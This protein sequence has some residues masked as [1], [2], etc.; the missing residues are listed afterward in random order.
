MKIRAFLI[1]LAILATSLP[2]NAQTKLV[3]SF[4]DACDS[5]ST[6]V[7]ERTSVDAKLK[8]RTITQRGSSLDFY[9]TN[10][11]TD[12]PWTK[13]DVKWFREALLDLFPSDAPA[14]SVGS[15][16]G[17]NININELTTNA[18]HFDGTV[19][20][21]LHRTSDHRGRTMV[22]RI[23]GQEFEKGLSGRHLAVWQSHGRYYETKTSRWEWQR[24]QNFT[25]VEDMYTQ[26]YVIP[27]LIPMLENAGAYVLSPR[28]R[29]TQ[30][31]EAVV[32]N[33]P[34]FALPRPDK[35]RKSGSYRESGDWYNAGMGFADIKE[36]YT[37]DDNPF[38]M[39]TARAAKVHPGSSGETKVTWTPD[40]PE[41]GR[42]AV[43]VSY[44][45]LSNSS[46]HAH[47]TVRHKG[48]ETEFA[49]NQKMGGSTWI[50]L[51][52]FDFDKEGG[53]VILD[54]KA[55]EGMVNKDGSVITADAVRFGGGMG[56][57]ARGNDDVPQDEW[58]TSGMP[59]YMEG[60]LY[61]M[62]WAG[63]DTTIIRKHP[64]DYTNDFADRGPWAAMMSGGSRVNPKMEGKGIPFDLS[65]A[66]HSD[67]GTFPNDSIIGTLSIYTLKEDGSRKYPDGEDRMACRDLCNYVQSQVV[68]D[69]RERYEPEWARREIWDRSY[70]EARTS[71]VPGMILELLSHQNFADMKYGLD[72]AFRFDVS[73]AV[74]KGVLKFLSDRYGCPYEVQPL[75][76]H[77]FASVLT[78]NGVT[79]SWAPTNDPIEPTAV[80]RGFILYTRID[81]GAFDDGRIIDAREAGG[82]YKA[83]V[84]MDPGHIYSFRIA[85]FND[86]GVSFPSETL[87]AGIPESPVSGDKVM[88]VNNFSRVSAPAWFDTPDYAGFDYALDSGVPYMYDISYIGQQY[89]FRRE[90]EWIDDDNPGFGGSYTDEAGLQAAGNTFDY[91]YVHG[92][93]VL[94]RG[95]AFS[96]MG[97]DA[98]A[99]D[100][101]LASGY[102]SMDVICGKQVTTS[103]GRGAVEDRYQVFPAPLQKA[104]SDYTAKGGNILIS[105]S[106]IGTDVWDQIYPAVHKDASYVSRT[107]RF[108]E[109]VLGYRWLT[110]YASRSGML[111]VMRTKQ[112]N[113]DAVTARFAFHNRPNEEVYCVETPDGIVP[114]DKDGSTFL[115]Y[116]DTNISAAVCCDKKT[117]RAISFGFPLET[118]KDE[119]DIEKLIGIS[120]DWFKERE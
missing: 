120:M 95:Y 79:L 86:G 53:C 40:I 110:N 48:G 68:N 38:Q 26:S 35:V 4:K 31:N 16:F 71:K 93:A 51:G 15:I 84:S 62:Q 72:P 82:R 108:V 25:T 17:N 43:Y 44:K 57:I 116:T 80:S 69:I 55:P 41:R 81:D 2:G 36:T 54:D 13:K 74:Y 109:D 20:E 60:A 34:A 107:K 106:N 75:P 98:F 42:Y 39:G 112:M 49:V 47:Y 77:N 58:E 12:I 117:Y 56:K 30:R 119:E 85:A 118:L 14:S 8:L 101:A 87:S 23:G 66:F 115:R 59:A 61:S 73:R 76:V 32:D 1:S 94:A 65:L 67:A 89:Q 105:G 99:N 22:Q 24:A 7:K 3:R 10:S 102:W 11:L 45:T 104:I 91:P 70:S 27:F 78:N 28:E 18:L 46:E 50:Y 90:L 37:G 97:S 33:D 92:K 96:S 63:V 114:A 64:D 5:L 6:L 52:S 111:W 113:T 19:H 100:S 21:T 103:M 29:D 83:E 9:F 88:I